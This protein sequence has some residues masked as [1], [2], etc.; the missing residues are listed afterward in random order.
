LFAD[1]YFWNNVIDAVTLNGTF[2]TCTLGGG[3]ANGVLLN[4]TCIYDAGENV[5]LG[6]ARV[7][8]NEVPGLTEN[9]LAVATDIEMRR[10]LQGLDAFVVGMCVPVQRVGEKL[11]HGLAEG[12][13]RVEVAEHADARIGGEVATPAAVDLQ[14]KKGRRH[15]PGFHVR[16]FGPRGLKG[17]PDH[18]FRN[19]GDGTFSDTSVCAGVA[20]DSG[21]YG[22]GVAFF[23]FDDELLDQ[24]EARG[25]GTRRAARG[26]GAPSCAASR[27]RP[28]PGGSR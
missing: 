26:A 3:L 24:F 22:F 14:I 15:V 12:I 4:L 25:E 6:L 2:D 21:L 23:D 19:E 9:E 7:P 27:R 11:L 16:R 17:A 1:S 5:D 18:M 10:D 28:R 13:A 20:D 8:F